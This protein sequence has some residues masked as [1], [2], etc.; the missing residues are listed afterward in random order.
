MYL[1]YATVIAANAEQIRIALGVLSYC[2]YY[3]NCTGISNS[4]PWYRQRDVRVAGTP[5]APV[6]SARTID[7]PQDAFPEDGSL[8]IS[9]PARFDCNNIKGFS[10][11][12]PFSSTGDTLTIGRRLRQRGGPRPVRGAPGPRD[13]HRALQRLARE[14]FP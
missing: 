9:S 2:R 12:E 4:T 8:G 11:P 6:V 5:N 1:S 10:V 13:R 3:S 7:V 14:A